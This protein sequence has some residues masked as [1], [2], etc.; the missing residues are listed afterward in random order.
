M[1]ALGFA[2]LLVGA[3]LIVAEAH[4][5][6]GVLGVIGGLGLVAGGIL[7]IGALGGGAV[8]AVPVAI[9]I[10]AGT[11]AWMLI[12]TRKAARV[13]RGRIQSGAEALC[14]HL[15]VVRHWR[16]PTGQV[17]VDGALWRAEHDWSGRDERAIE[18]GEHVVVT[19]VN[20][21]TLTV[22]RAEDWELVA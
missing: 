6:G 18:D 13:Q 2:L 14:G 17:F 9:G 19:R 12:V 7:V 22:R 11:G 8:L 21:L 5:P 1:T 10:A 4:A 16:E 20:G 3:V 15:G